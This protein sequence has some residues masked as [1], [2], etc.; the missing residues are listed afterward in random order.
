MAGSVVR[1]LLARR[2]RRD[3]RERPRQSLRGIPPSKSGNAPHR[4][5]PRPHA[6]STQAPIAMSIAGIQW[7]YPARYPSKQAGAGREWITSATPERSAENLADVRRRLM[8]LRA[9]EGRP[10]SHQ[11]RTQ[12]LLRCGRG[13]PKRITDSWAPPLPF[14]VL[15][16]ENHQGKL[17]DASMASI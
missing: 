16:S 3:G 6:L 8:G 15:G 11:N 1:K 2:W 7:W 10:G 12:F 14:P 9:A 17:T 4:P 5:I 13:R